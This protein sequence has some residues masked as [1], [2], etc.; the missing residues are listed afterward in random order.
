MTVKLLALDVDGVLTDGTLYYSADGEAMKAFNAQDG[1]GLKL[2]ERLG[3]HVAIISGRDSAALNKRLDDLGIKLRRLRC[4]NKVVALQEICDGLGIDI[5]EAAFMG[6]DLV[7]LKVM[8]ACGHPLAPANAVP[9][10]HM[11]ADHV[12]HARGGEG[13]VREV[14]EYLADRMGTPLMD[15]LYMDDAHTGG[16][17]Q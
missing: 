12:P 8:E 3:I 1:L 13:A 17:T 9:A 14:C 11:V 16:L 6:D 2:L 4:G 15:A 7:D 5:S 10:I